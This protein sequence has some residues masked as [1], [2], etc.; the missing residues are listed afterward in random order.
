MVGEKEDQQKH[1]KDKIYGFGYSKKD[2]QNKQIIQIETKTWVFERIYFHEND[3]LAEYFLKWIKSNPGNK[4]PEEQTQTEEPQPE[5]SPA[6]LFCC[7]KT[8]GTKQNQ[9][10]KKK[11]PESD[12]KTKP[13]DFILSV[14]G[15]ASNFVLKRRYVIT[16]LSETLYLIFFKRLSTVLI[17]FSSSFY[18]Q[19]PF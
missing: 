9:S 8:R 6:S 15:G 17:C 13:P 4:E 12:D 11:E 3:T 1:W 19:N 2:N 5:K 10:A 14:A 7:G 18:C 16:L